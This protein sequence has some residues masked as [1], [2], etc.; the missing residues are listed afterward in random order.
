MSNYIDFA[1]APKDLCKINPKLKN[2]IITYNEFANNPHYEDLTNLLTT[3]QPSAIILFE[4][5]KDN[6]TG[7]LLGHYGCLKRN[8]YGEN[9]DSSKKGIYFFDSYGGYPG[10]QIESANQLIS[11]KIR[12]KLRNRMFKS[13]KNKKYSLRYNEKKLQ[14]PD[15]MTC[16]RYCALF[17]IDPRETPEKFADDIKKLGK[18]N[19]LSP[20][21]II[22]ELT[23]VK[24]GK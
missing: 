22:L 9:G 14:G 13:K 21:Q 2:K 3:N 17:S 18:I 6:S 10:R 12:K 20:D 1:L 19:G 11:K 8:D 7:G 16:G 24:L 15:S 4:H 5:T 23:G